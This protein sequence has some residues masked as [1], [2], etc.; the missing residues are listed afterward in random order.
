M[1][2]TQY[3]TGSLALGLAVFS[4][5]RQEVIS[6][7]FV[8]HFSPFSLI[9]FTFPPVPVVVW[10]MVISISLLSIFL[11]LRFPTPIH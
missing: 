6:G 5:G 3:V 10:G 8:M 1:F 7:H 2:R 4:V 11:S 9:P